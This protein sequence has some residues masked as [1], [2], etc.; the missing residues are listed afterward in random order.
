MDEL[1]AVDDPER[2]EL[3]EDGEKPMEDEPEA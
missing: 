1:T 2:K 3:L